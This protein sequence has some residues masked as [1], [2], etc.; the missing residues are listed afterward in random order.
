MTIHTP[1][2][3]RQ[4]EAHKAI[5]ARLWGKKPTEIKTAPPVVAKEPEK[6]LVQLDYHVW[7]YRKFMI[8][9]GVVTAITTRAFFHADLPSEYQS[10][11]QNIT[12]DL[13][14]QKKSMERIATEV[15]LDFEGITLEDIRGNSQTRNIAYPR[16]VAMHRIK[17][18][19]PDLSYPQIGRWFR[20]D[21]TTVIHA[22][23]K[24]EA[25]KDTANGV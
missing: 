16:Q 13:I 21:H 25:M 18:L 7:L 11:Q 23:R 12:F 6:K 20:R 2:L 1:E 10:Y 8:Q 4:N 5:Q 15:L 14:G 22:V 17:M 19:R 3:L 24:I 9:Y